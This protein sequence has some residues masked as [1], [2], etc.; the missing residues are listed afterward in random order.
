MTEVT[1]F[2]RHCYSVTEVLCKHGFSADDKVLIKSL[3]LSATELVQTATH[4]R[5]LYVV[6]SSEVTLSLTEHLPRNS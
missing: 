6:Y 3:Y 2:P 5:S 4:L 1:R